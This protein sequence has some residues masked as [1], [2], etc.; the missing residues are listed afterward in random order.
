MQDLDAAAAWFDEN[1]IQYVKGP[2]AGKMKDADFIKD[3]DGY[4]IESVEPARL[5]NLGL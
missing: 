5:G 2:D 3:P 4:W 1:K